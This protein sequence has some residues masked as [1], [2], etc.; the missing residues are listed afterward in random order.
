MF[1]QIS[2][3]L[4]HCFWAKRLEFF[5]FFQN[6][7]LPLQFWRQTNG[8]FVCEKMRAIILPVF[9][10]EGGLPWYGLILRVFYFLSFWSMVNNF[11]SIICPRNICPYQEYLSCYWPDFD[12]TLQVGSWEH[13]EKLPTVTVTFVQAI[14]VQATFVLV[15]FVHIRNISAVTDTIWTKL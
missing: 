4:K 7:N 2:P 14:L 5:S 10:R 8:K 15:T 13:L 6:A 3:F 9:F 11:Q 1:M 12:E